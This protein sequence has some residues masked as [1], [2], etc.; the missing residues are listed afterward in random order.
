MLTIII[1]FTV[2]GIIMISLEVLLPGGIMGIGGALAIATA[3]ILTAASPEL[4]YLGSGGRVLLGI[5]I[6]VF[7]AV[8]LLLWLKYFTSAGLMKKHLLQNDVGGTNHYAKYQELLD[9]TG[10]AET[11]LRPAGKA[12]FGGVR[13]DVMAE[14]GLIA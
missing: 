6:I 14:T 4:D 8:S 2:F 5:G 10:S 13:H 9:A 1:I 3:L 11:D 7:T 12:K